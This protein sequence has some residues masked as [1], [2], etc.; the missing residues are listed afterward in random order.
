[1]T[2]KDDP[3]RQFLKRVYDCHCFTV[4]CSQKSCYFSIFSSNS[5][6]KTSELV[7]NLEEMFPRKL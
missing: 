2:K 1:M 4:A 7:E 5:E 3:N 6:E